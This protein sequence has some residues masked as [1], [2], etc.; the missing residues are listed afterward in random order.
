MVVIMK[1]NATHEDIDK[2]VSRIESAGLQAQKSTGEQHTL[3]GVIGDKSKLAN[4][5][6]ESMKGVDRTMPI[7]A[8]YKLASRQFRDEPTVIESNGTKIGS[9]QLVVIAGPCAVENTEQIVRIAQEIK[10]SG[11]N[12]IRGGAFKPRTGPYS[13]Q[14]FGKS[15]LEMLVCARN[16]TGL[17]IVTE[18]MTPH[19]VELVGQYTDIFQLGTRNMQNFYLLRE[20][21]KQQKPVILKRG[22]SSTIEEWL[23]AA[24]YIL[25]EGNPNVILCE[26]GIRTFE[27]HTRNTLD[28]NA[29]PAIKELSHLPIISDPSH[30]TGIRSY[31]APMSKASIAAG[32]DGLILEVHHDPDNSMTG[33]G[34]QSLFPDQFSI[35][36]NDLKHL[37]TAI[38]RDMD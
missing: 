27:T 14:G 32:A 37:A 13:F 5:P 4:Q 3:I 21:G 9:R 38:G 17:G 7:S 34:V 1:P 24:E 10:M 28:L 2:V 11:A 19:E 16:E 22:F 6:I 12:F 36:M 18:V 29:I 26:R 15:A 20:V 30:G 31:V 23:L 8:P 35:L 33:D 25:S